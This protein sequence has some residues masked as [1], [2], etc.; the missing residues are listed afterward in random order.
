MPNLENTHLQESDKANDLPMRPERLFH[1]K[2]FK[3]YFHD[4][5]PTKFEMPF[6]LLE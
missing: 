6:A 1:Y 4:S 5:S 3:F 2:N